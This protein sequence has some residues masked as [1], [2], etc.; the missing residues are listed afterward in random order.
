MLYCTLTEKK[1]LHQQGRKSGDNSHHLNTK[2][3]QENHI[4]KQFFICIESEFK[5]T[6]EN[7]FETTCSIKFK[8]SAKSSPSII[9]ND[10]V[11]DD[12]WDDFLND[13]SLHYLNPTN[14]NNQE[15]TLKNKV[16]IFRYHT[17]APVSKQ[18]N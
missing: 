5:E 13:F 6:S 15:F 4:V 7:N 12:T 8:N 3:N 2:R 18:E 1:W 14:S 17:T 9:K 16:P 11:N 10:N